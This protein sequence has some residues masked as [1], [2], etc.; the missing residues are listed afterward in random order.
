MLRRGWDAWCVFWARAR[1]NRNENENE[2]RQG[3]GASA[4]KKL[5]A[6]IAVLAV[7]FAA[8]A[9]VMPAI[10]ESDAA[11][12]VGAADPIGDDYKVTYHPKPANKDQAV[13]GNQA[14]DVK[15]ENN[16]FTFDGFVTPTTGQWAT[17]DVVATGTFP[18]L[19]SIKETNPAISGDTNKGTLSGDKKTFTMTVPRGNNGTVT[20]E[21]KDTSEKDVKLTFDFTKV[22]TKQVL[23][24]E[25]TKGTNAFDFGFSTANGLTLENYTGKDL[26]YY[27]GDLTVTLKGTNTISAYG[28][29]D[30]TTGN[31]SS[32]INAKNITIKADGDNASLKSTQNTVGAFNISA[33]VAD[34][35]NITIGETTP[36]S[37]KVT[38]TAEG[39]NRALYARGSITINNSDLTLTAS[40]KTIRSNGTVEI[41][42]STVSAKLD[43][44]G[45]Q[46]GDDPDKGLYGIISNGNVTVGENAKVDAQS[47]YVKGNNT[48]L[49]V[50][51]EITVGDAIVDKVTMRSGSATFNGTLTGQYNS[52][53]GIYKD[54]TIDGTAGTAVLGSK[55]DLNKITKADSCTAG[56]TVDPSAMED[57]IVGGT[58]TGK[59]S[60]TVYPI[61][62][63]VTVTGSW[64]LAP[65]ANITI[66][67]QFILP[68][69]A[70][71]TIQ[72]GASLTLNP[73]SVSK[74]DGKVVIEEKD[75]NNTGDKNGKLTADGKV[76]VTGSVQ[77]FGDIVV[78]GEFSIEADAVVSVED[79]G[80]ILTAAGS[81]LTVKDSGALE[82][83][84]AFGPDEDNEMFEVYNY[85]L[86]TIDSEV[87]VR[88]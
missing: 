12:S 61:N 19:T 10:D 63:I 16:T 65:G 27:S 60:N 88:A 1:R 87:A 53:A 52:V 48:E 79:A 35:A 55:V 68:A 33:Q 9:V 23:S 24:S 74:I 64:T 21:F 59:D 78:G 26:F 37:K 20:L 2:P 28:N 83:R 86:V 41:V 69:D 71:L 18:E 51:G 45:Q 44:T 50:T 31:G 43:G 11:T 15:Y 4:S 56:I 54:T 14:L 57:M 80:S 77:S 66:Q 72:N 30:Y 8:F 36:G 25:V 29:P 67:G 46:N 39:G 40:E 34:G 76:S 70:T 84:G 49:T 6:A 32:I 3:G 73:G 81:K 58:T 62:Q 22:S 85:G 13:G 5:L 38:L 42:N 7:M 17:I 47:L 75:S 82:I